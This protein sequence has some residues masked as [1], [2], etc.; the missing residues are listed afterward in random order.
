MVKRPRFHLAT[1]YQSHPKT[2]SKIARIARQRPYIPA[3][4]ARYNKTSKAQVNSPEQSRLWT[5]S[6]AKQ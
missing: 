5:L 4:F 6:C 2:N 1:I 3:F